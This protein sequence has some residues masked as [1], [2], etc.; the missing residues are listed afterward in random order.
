MEFIPKF[1]IFSNCNWCYGLYDNPFRNGLK[2]LLCNIT[3][4]TSLKSY[5]C[6]TINHNIISGFILEEFL[7]YL[8]NLKV[9]Y[10][11]N[12]SINRYMFVIEPS[13]ENKNTTVG[14]FYLLYV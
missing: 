9:I 12:V 2:F 5:T 7:G 14:I 6:L 13:Q 11:L 8:R 3:K 1:P 10:S 4:N